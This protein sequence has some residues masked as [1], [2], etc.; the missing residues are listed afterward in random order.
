MLQFKNKGGGVVVLKDFILAAVGGTGG[1]KPGRETKIQYQDADF[2][3]EFVNLS[4]TSEIHDKA[5]IKGC[6]RYSQ[7]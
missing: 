6:I 2:G 5:T 1:C 4:V 7:Q 3:N